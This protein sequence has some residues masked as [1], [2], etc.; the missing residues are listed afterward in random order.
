MTMCL[1]GQ[2][3]KGRRNSQL[4]VQGGTRLDIERR[5]IYRPGLTD[6]QTLNHLLQVGYKALNLLDIN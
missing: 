1:T 3:Y 2:C 4:K 5:S 6:K